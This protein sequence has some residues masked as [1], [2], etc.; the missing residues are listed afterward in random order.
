VRKPG[1]PEWHAHV[2]ALLT[3]EAKQPV[4]W[5]YLSFV[6]H[7]VFQGACLVEARGM[8]QALQESHRLGINPGGEVMSIDMGA[9]PGHLPVNRLLSR[10]EME[11]LGCRTLG[12]S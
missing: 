3:E 8:T 12:E 11:E 5:W 6:D 2:D 4:H 9:D 10:S 7:G 1:S